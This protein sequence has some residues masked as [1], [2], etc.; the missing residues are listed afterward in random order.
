MTSNKP[1]STNVGT[2]QFCNTLNI[3]NT[4][5]STLKALN[6]TILICAA[7]DH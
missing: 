5:I 4:K 2:S 7:K 6:S 3:Q 1:A